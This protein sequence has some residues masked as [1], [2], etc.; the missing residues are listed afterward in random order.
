[1]DSLRWSSADANR[2][3]QLRLL[4]PP[5]PARRAFLLEGP[6]D[7][8]TVADPLVVIGRLPRRERSRFHFRRRRLPQLLIDL[9]PV[10]NLADAVV[11]VD[12]FALLVPVAHLDEGPHTLALRLDSR[13]EPLGSRRTV[14]FRRASHEGALVAAEQLKVPVRKL[15]DRVERVEVLVG[16]QPW[17]CGSWFCGRN[18]DGWLGV[19]ELDLG[20]LPPGLHLLR[21]RPEG[22]PTFTYRLE[23]LPR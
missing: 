14:H 19:A 21:I 5:P 4:P 10:A 23:R 17:P 2:R 1:M 18:G 3:P 22:H 20:A 12:R 6:L 9:R 16:D 7:G 8:E 15:G 11:A 13:D